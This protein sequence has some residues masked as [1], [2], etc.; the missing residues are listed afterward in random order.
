MCK[1]K[2]AWKV[3]PDVETVSEGHIGVS[4]LVV[5]AGIWK[6]T[7]RYFTPRYAG[8]WDWIKTVVKNWGEYK[9]IDYVIG[10]VQS[11]ANDGAGD[12]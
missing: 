9:R 5:S 6:Q 12:R 11:G 8:D 1:F 10:E 3:L 2:H 7:S 4:A